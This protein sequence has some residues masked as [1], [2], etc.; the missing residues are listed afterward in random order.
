MFLDLAL[1]ENRLKT[2]D[3]QLLGKLL[4]TLKVLKTVVYQKQAIVYFLEQAV[5]VWDARR[6]TSLIFWE[7]V[8]P[9]V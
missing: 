4:P 1:K 8:Q 9:S 5:T 7:T 3:L 6:S 2:E